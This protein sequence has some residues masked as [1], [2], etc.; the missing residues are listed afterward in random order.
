MAQ[1]HTG[2]KESLRTA[3]GG[4]RLLNSTHEHK[5]TLKHTFD[6]N[7]TKMYDT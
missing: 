5:K 2:R 3:L 1:R 6:Q 7:E 4:G